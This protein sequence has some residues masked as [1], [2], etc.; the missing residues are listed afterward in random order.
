MKINGEKVSIREVIEVEI[1]R[2]NASSLKLKVC[3]YP[4]GIAR[5]YL[6]VFPTPV[7]P[8]K[9]TGVTT[10]KS[11]VETKPDYDD[12]EFVKA[13]A[14]FVWLEK[15]FH[16][17]KCLEVDESIKF[18]SDYTTLVGLRNIPKELNEAGFSEGDIGKILGAI[19]AATIIEPKAVEKAAE[20]FSSSLATQK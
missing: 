16:I 15:F 13:Y 20:L 8:N 1:S 9:S 6:K 18:D 14:E 4:I 12:P 10:V 11:G 5:E 3:G 7:P 17:C 19:N 2:N